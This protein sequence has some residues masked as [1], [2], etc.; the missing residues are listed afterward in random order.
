MSTIDSRVVQ[1]N[2]DNSKF[3][4]GVSSTLGMLDKLKAALGLS[5]AS[6]GL[7]DVN[8]AAGA[9][10]SAPMEQGVGRISTAFS[11]MQA[12]A[13][14]ALANIGA[15]I[16]DTALNMANSF[17]LEPLKAGFD[18]YELKMGSIQT[19]LAN[20]A[21]DG[22][23]LDQVNEQFEILND[24]AD[25]T[26]YNFG[27]MTRNIGLFTN[28]GIGLEDATQ[29]I[30]GFSNSAAASG[31]NATDAARAA[32]QLSQ[33]LSAGRL[34]AID[35]F[36]LT[37]A[38]M[39]GQ[40]MKDSLIDIAS[41]MGTFEGTGTTATE[42]ATDFKG[43]LESGW[44][45]AD[46]MSTYLR[47]MAGDMDD[48]SLAAM[49][50]SQESIDMLRQQ[51]TMGDEA[52]RKVRTFSQ[53][54]GTLKESVGSGWAETFQIVF[55][56]FEE[57]TELFTMLNDNIGGFLSR[58][59]DSRNTML[60]E[61]ATGFDGLSGRK[62]LIEGL[63]EA[64][65]ALAAPLAQVGQAFRQIFPA[66]T[67]RQLFDM[68]VAFRDFMIEIRP[69]PE[70]LDRIQR[71]FAGLFAILHI[72]WTVI[73]ATATFL[74]DMLLGFS[75]GD[76]GILRFTASI[77]DFFV[78]LDQ[79]ISS[80]QGLTNFFTNLR[81][82]LFTV[83]NPIRD[84]GRAIGEF[85]EGAGLSGA[86]SSL[87][88][89]IT[90]LLSFGTTAGE[91]GEDAVTFMDRVKSV[92]S[93][94]AGFASDVADFIRPVTDAIADALQNLDFDKL[95]D[96]LQ[97]LSLGG[98]ALFIKQ[99][100]G[101]FSGLELFKG[102]GGGIVDSIKEGLDGL[103]GTL[104]A[105]QANL[106]ASM[107]LKIAGAI[108]LLAVSVVLLAS[109]DGPGLVRAT[110]ALTVM[111]IQLGA[112]MAVFQK[113]GTVASMAKL[114]VM[115]A[116]L[117]LIAGAIVILTV[118]VKQLAELSWEEL[119]KGLGALVVMMGVIIGLS[120]GMDKSRG[121]VLRSAAALVIVAF[122]IKQLVDVVKELG[123]MDLDEMRQGLIGVGALLIGLAIFSRL[124]EGG[125]GALTGA[126]SMLILAFALKT[127]AEVVDMFAQMSWGEMAKGFAGIA[128]G[129]VLM[130]VALKAMPG[131]TK[132]IFSALAIGKVAGAMS[133]IALAIKQFDDIS[134]ETLAKG[135]IG[136]G[137]A[138]LILTVAMNKM[139]KIGIGQAASLAVVGIAIKI[140]AEA[141]EVL[142]AMD[143]VALGISMG[144]LAVILGILV[145][146]LNLMQ[147]TMAGAAAILIVAAAL[148][149]LVPVIVTMGSLPWQVLALGIAGLAAVFI[150]LGVAG[151][152]L[153]PLTPTLIAL[154]IAIGLIGA[155][156][157]LAGL[158]VFLFATGL[159][160]LA[161]AGGAAT[162]AI[163]AIV[164][165]LIGLIPMVME[166]IGLGL[167]AFAGVIATAG[168]AILAA[169]TAV[170][171]A[172]LQAIIDVTPKIVETLLVLLDALLTTIDQ[173]LPRIIQ[174]GINMIMA[175]LDGVQ[176]N[177]GGIVDKVSQIITNFLDALSRNLPSIIQSGIN[178]IVS[179]VQG[180][181]DGIRNNSQR[182]VD[183]GLDLV[184][185]IID[186]I[187]DGVSSLASR[188]I[189]AVKDLASDMLDGAMDMLG[190][191]GPSRRF[192][193]I[194]E[195]T[196][197]GMLLGIQKMNRPVAKSAEELGETAIDGMTKS[198]SG[199]GAML[200]A[201]ADMTP[202]IA[203]VL[204]LSGVRRDAA[205]IDSIISPQ[206]FNVGTSLNNANN[207]S[208][209]YRS[210][211][212]ARDDAE[213]NTGTDTLT[214]IQNNYSPKA[215][216]A[217]E[218]Y[219]NTKSQLSVAKE[220]LKSNVD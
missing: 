185:A 82:I 107:L 112:A 85:F 186:G 187:V 114:T 80:G 178:L 157:A 70:T 158:G 182:M 121:A 73:K 12:I 67:G 47:V 110:S 168:P 49:G 25:Q 60:E 126:A 87:G 142:G 206:P 137:G 176:R 156:V 184:D 207:A 139:P 140:I 104:S 2:F 133:L 153:A 37:N 197:T 39:G 106:K 210:N 71:T 10:N 202:V 131:G 14:G 123:A 43:S 27:D 93:S 136:I 92:F 165:G 96:A 180:L 8:A 76:S 29:M 22:T 130:G 69:G 88:N 116:A 9:F 48:A 213:T 181:A 101:M 44:L 119:A 177:I 28:A 91:A 17:T 100:G 193:E 192:E 111:F 167:V 118:A 6:R 32:T 127:L 169:I 46:V 77:G 154:G 83:L 166:Q 220:A 78:G 94:I 30:R 18:E 68:T 103:T 212:E 218:T 35:W 129:L 211:Q 209:G 74:K 160:A 62:V 115:G 38:G 113:I 215:I 170:L 199:L 191:G 42:A 79:A 162:A 190:I 171:L 128:I 208:A 20:T 53:L 58:I 147:G 1:M 50:L 81:E 66:T 149:V 200:N 135:I 173:A 98:I 84:A 105:M 122:A 150:V 132:L 40:N 41:A 198:L 179:F 188:A 174:S 120:Q 54:M 61:W 201:D 11:S 145:V 164:S 205:A 109:V 195:W 108:A 134:W 196:G 4:T 86:G 36:S 124:Q 57:A 102:A 52:A 63:Q 56:D 144:A 219:R 217:A 125:S 99:L 203:P 155:A 19:I 72:G 33:A 194:G 117:I 34:T 45:E 59:G 90:G 163:V 138:L 24:Y 16:S 26:I 189:N 146:S 172:F 64:F 51:A 3:A 152:L 97:T 23:T 13:F 7:Q 183:A 151:L 161:V 204:D 21:R 15:K 65:W 175:L 214:F 141:M 5:G 95:M 75:D 148:N 216:S 31:T 89:L 159:T 143:V 55:G